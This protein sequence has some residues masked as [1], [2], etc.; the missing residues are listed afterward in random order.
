MLRQAVSR[1]GQYINWL[2]LFSGLTC[3]SRG[4]GDE[5]KFVSARF[6]GLQIIFENRMGNK[7]F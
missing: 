1:F 3:Q 7:A 6:Y 4:R 2:Y 5:N